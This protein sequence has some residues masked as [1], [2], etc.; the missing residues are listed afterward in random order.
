[1]KPR[2]NIAI[3]HRSRAYVFARCYYANNDSVSTH[4]YRHLKSGRLWA[5]KAVHGEW[6]GHD[7]GE[8]FEVKR[9]RKAT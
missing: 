9:K 4:V 8:W 6:S 5:H 1:M 7:D 3:T 2:G